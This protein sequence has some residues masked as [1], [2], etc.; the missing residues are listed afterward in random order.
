MYSQ[1]AQIYILCTNIYTLHFFQERFA[2]HVR[3]LLPLCQVEILRFKTRLA[4]RWKNTRGYD[5]GCKGKHTC[6]ECPAKRDGTMSDEGANGNSRQH[7]AS[8]P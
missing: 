4:L 3:V 8:V 1:F 6:V 5:L 2:G 7:V